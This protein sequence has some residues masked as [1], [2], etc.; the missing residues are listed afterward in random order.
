MLIILFR[1]IR[2]LKYNTVTHKYIQ[3]LFITFFKKYDLIKNFFF[4]LYR[5][6]FPHDVMKV[7]TLY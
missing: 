1:Q 3:L 7:T 5:V 2:V 4:L 6:F